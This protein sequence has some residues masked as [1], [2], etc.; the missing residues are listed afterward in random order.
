MAKNKPH[1]GLLKRIRI[2]KTGLVRHRKAGCKHLKS[3]KSPQRLRRLRGAS[4]MSTA[5]TKRLSKLLSRRLR[6]KEQPRTALRR[7]PTPAERK[8]RRDAA[9][10]AVAKK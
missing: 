1:K 7:S 9:K 5:E 8:A 2:T 6:G 10:A 4:W 3:S